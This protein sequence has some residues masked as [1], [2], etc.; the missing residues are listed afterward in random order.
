[1][2]EAVLLPPPLQLTNGLPAGVCTRVPRVDRLV[3]LV[4][5]H[6]ELG[7]GGAVLL[8]G[9]VPLCLQRVDLRLDLPDLVALGLR[10]LS[11]PGELRLD[12]AESLGVFRAQGLLD[13]L[14]RR[15][16][17]APADLTLE[18]QH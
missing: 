8:I 16:T 15:L 12:L 6:V 2:H 10:L 9:R 14:P 3:Q 4:A 13:L 11:T 5:G 1:D 7:L 18:L 17:G